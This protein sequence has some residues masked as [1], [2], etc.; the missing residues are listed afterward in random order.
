MASDSKQG[1]GGKG[2]CLHKIYIYIFLNSSTTPLGPTHT[3]IERDAQ[4]IT[5]NLSKMCALLWQFLLLFLFLFLLLLLC[6]FLLM[7]IFL[8]LLFLLQISCCCCCHDVIQ[9]FNQNQNQ[10]AHSSHEVNVLADSYNRFQGDNK[11]KINKSQE[12][13]KGSTEG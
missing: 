6:L 10:S 9:Y 1:V 12:A 13:H 8:L 5:A 7:L 3:P 4:Q 2:E 11:S